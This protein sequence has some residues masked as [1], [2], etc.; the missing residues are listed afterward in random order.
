MAAVCWLTLKSLPGANGGGVMVKGLR[1]LAPLLSSLATF[2]GTS[3]LLKAEEF[4][5]L[6]KLSLRKK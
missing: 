1:L 5:H 3:V 2:A 4:N 6:V